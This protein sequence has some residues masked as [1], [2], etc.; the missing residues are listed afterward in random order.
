MMQGIGFR[1]VGL[2][3]RIMALVFRVY[4]FKGFKFLGFRNYG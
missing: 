3:V 2:R 4:G 1:V